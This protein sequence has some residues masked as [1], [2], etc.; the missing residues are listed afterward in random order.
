M[1]HAPQSGQGVRRRRGHDLARCAAAIKQRQYRNLSRNSR[2]I[3]RKNL[4]SRN[5]RETFR[6]NL[7]RRRRSRGSLGGVCACSWAAPGVADGDVLPASELT[8]LP[9]LFA[10]WEGGSSRGRGHVRGARV[11]RC[12]PG[13]PARRFIGCHIGC[14]SHRHVKERR[15]NNARY[16]CDC[17]GFSRRPAPAA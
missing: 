10:W 6:R 8:C 1:R 9:E 15:C 5:V 4:L 2:N 3:S 14:V 16:T 7:S 11:S 17:C 13:D 12:R